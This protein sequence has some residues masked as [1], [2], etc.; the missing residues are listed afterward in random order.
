[1]S[2]QP[3]KSPKQEIFKTTADRVEQLIE[4]EKEIE[5]ILGYIQTGQT[6]KERRTENPYYSKPKS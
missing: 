6:R 4:Q 3:S 1:M 5:R 2:D